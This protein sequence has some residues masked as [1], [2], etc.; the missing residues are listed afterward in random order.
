MQ[1]DA[2]LHVQDLLEGFGVAVS[3]E[4]N[5]VIDKNH[6]RFVWGHH[7]LWEKHNFKFGRS[8]G[9]LKWSHMGR[10]WPK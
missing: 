8:F 1:R 7:H 4:L 5:V 3:Q 10:P 9:D 6:G 2:H